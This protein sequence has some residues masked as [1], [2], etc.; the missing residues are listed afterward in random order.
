MKKNQ[1]IALLSLILGILGNLNSNVFA[2]RGQESPEN[3]ISNVLEFDEAPAEPEAP[4]AAPV[5]LNLLLENDAILDRLNMQNPKHIIDAIVRICNLTR[6]GLSDE[7]SLA[8]LQHHLLRLGMNNINIVSIGTGMTALHNAILAVDPVDRIELVQI[9]IALG[10]GVN[11]R[12]TRPS[13]AQLHV[14]PELEGLTDLTPLHLAIIHGSDDVV[15]FLAQ[16]VNVNIEVEINNDWLNQEDRRIIYFAHEYGSP[17][18]FDIIRQA[19]TRRGLQYNRTMEQADNS[20]DDDQELAP[21][22]FDLNQ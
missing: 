17:G 3:R 5:D 13:D 7:E 14:N 11:A 2:A 9:L 6:V 22:P 16:H 15:S 12:I 20:D 4:E 8:I 21:I 10:A 19:Y 1:K 18:A